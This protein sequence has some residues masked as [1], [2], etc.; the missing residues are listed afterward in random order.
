MAALPAPQAAGAI[1]AI[2]R[3]IRLEARLVEAVVAVVGILGGGRFRLP[4]N[5][6]R[7]CQHVVF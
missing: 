6:F 1:R 7:L 5:S 4:V 3:D 2:P